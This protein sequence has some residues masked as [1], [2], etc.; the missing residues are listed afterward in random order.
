VAGGRGKQR[1]NARHLRYGA[2]IAENRSGRT[3]HEH[4]PALWAV[5]RDTT[6]WAG[7]VWAAHVAWSGNHSVFAEV[8]PDGRK[9]AQ[10]GE[11]LHPGELCLEPGEKYETPL[12]VAAH[13]ERGMNEASWVLHR[14][15]RANN[16]HSSMREPRKVSLNTWEAVYFNHDEQQLRALAN[17][18]NECGVE[19][20]VLDDGWFGARRNDAAGLGD[21]VVSKDVYPQGLAPLISHVRSLGMEFGIWVE[22]EM[23]NVDSNVYRQHPEWVL[24]EPGYSAIFSRN[25]LVLNLAIPEA[26]AHVEQQLDALLSDHDIAYV[27][28]DMNR[29]HVHGSGADG[30]AGS[31][32]QTLAVYR[33][34]DSLRAKH[35]T[36]EFESCA[37]GGGRID[38]AM[39]QR[40][41]RVW[42][43]DCN[44]ALESPADSEE[45]FHAGA[46]RGAGCA[47]WPARCTHHGQKAHTCVSRSD[48]NVRPSGYRM[49]L[50]ASKAARVVGAFRNHCDLQET[51]CAF[52]QWKLC[53]IRGFCS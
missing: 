33:L 44:D 31:H 48:G 34:L 22:P 49:E 26:F 21:W 37:S 50:V 19:R 39:L 53:S 46:N 14:N 43:S 35:P 7:Q 12:V 1:C 11:L 6:E 42:T 52:A 16:K 9:Y 13:S 15:V 36:V 2:F 18:A 51:S 10:L 25:Q 8:L 28:W 20:F 27:K 40:T 24:S 29:A 4:I 30:A 38:H 17:T 32:H 5:Q 47:H 41:E 45:H 3:S 23:V